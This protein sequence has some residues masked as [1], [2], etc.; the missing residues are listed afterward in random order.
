MTESATT[1]QAIARWQDL[2]DESGSR[3]VVGDEGKRQTLIG[4][5][6]SLAD[7][8]ESH[9]E[10]PV[11]AHSVPIHTFADG[12]QAQQRRQVEYVSELT[13]V[14][15]EDPDEHYRVTLGFGPVQYT[16]VSI[17]ADTTPTEPRAFAD[18]DEVRLT[19]PRADSMRGLWP[20]TGTITSHHDDAYNVQFV[21]TYPA[22]TLRGA[23]L[24]PSPRLGR[25]PTQSGG[26]T[27]LASAE[28]QFEIAAGR[29]HARHVLGLPSIQADAEEAT[30]LLVVLSHACDLSPERLGDLLA[31]DVEAT[32]QVF[33]RMWSRTVSQAPVPLAALDQ[34]SQQTP[35]TTISQLRPKGTTPGHPA[36]N[37]RRPA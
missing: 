32:S 31:R 21:G 9:P 11:T 24:E 16:F 18:G 8:L 7:F 26:V 33:Q 30:R 3:F 15:A 28:T 34:P 17:P 36:D 25:I 35:P 4:G 6:R 29:E 22:T 10:I 13:G 2:T 37:S 23:D 20:L 27:A 5:L 12:T 19:G 1:T 14:P